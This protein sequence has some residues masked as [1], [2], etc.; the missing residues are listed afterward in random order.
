MEDV[1]DLSQEPLLVIEETVNNKLSKDSC[2]NSTPLWYRR[3]PYLK[4]IHIIEP[5]K[6]QIYI[7]QKLHL[8]SKCL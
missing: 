4:K 2:N 7:T 3:I 5:S 8:V 1:I 6:E